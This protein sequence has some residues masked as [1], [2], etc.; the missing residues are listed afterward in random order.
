MMIRHHEKATRD[1]DQCPDRAFHG[2]LR[3]FCAHVIAEQSRAIALLEGWLSDW[4]GLCQ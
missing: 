1:A 4:Y 3:Q 2:E